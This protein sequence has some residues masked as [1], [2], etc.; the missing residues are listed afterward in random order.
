MKIEEIKKMI[1][2][3]NQILK[4]TT[5]DSNILQTIAYGFDHL[6][7][8]TTDSLIPLLRTSINLYMREPN[9]IN[10]Y[11]W[12]NQ[13]G[14]KKYFK[15][16]KHT[17]L[18][19]KP[20]NYLLA[21]NHMGLFNVSVTRHASGHHNHL[22]QEYNNQRERIVYS[23]CPAKINYEAIQRIA[24]QFLRKE[25]TIDESEEKEVERLLQGVHSVEYINKIKKL[26]TL[27][28]KLDIRLPLDDSGDTFISPES[29]KAALHAVSITM[30]IITQAFK[31]KQSGL[32]IVRPPGHHAGTDFGEGFCIFNNVFASAYKLIQEG[33][34]KICIVDVDAHHGN[35]SLDILSRHEG[36]KQKVTL[37]DFY[38]G[39]NYHGEHGEW[40]PNLHNSAEKQ[41][42]DMSNSGRNTKTILDDL[43]ECLMNPYDFVIVS[44]GLDGHRND[45]LGG[46]L[47]YDDQFY[48]DVITLLQKLV[49]GKFGLVLEGGY[50]TETITRI[51]S[52]GIPIISNTLPGEEVVGQQSSMTAKM[53]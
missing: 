39:K 41:M 32:C 46:E 16:I 23:D 30:N 19:D 6:G 5:L 25:V 11:D 10:V 12:L 33:A 34:N 29:Y 28:E 22:K 15:L 49:P 48:T 27:S 7:K 43:K 20:N 52:S 36:L 38:D 8:L 45:P 14:W 31:N 4:T 3:I 18:N 44:F 26:S 51:M 42:C 47:G 1:D 2:G 35:G 9:N 53:F 40:P 37:Y 13:P 21:S 50:N 24:S 17:N